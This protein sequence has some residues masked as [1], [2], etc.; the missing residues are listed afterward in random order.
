MNAGIFSIQPSMYTAKLE[1]H[2][3][4]YAIKEN[5]LES[6]F[7]Y[8]HKD[9][10][11]RMKILSDKEIQKFLK[12]LKFWR[13]TENDYSL[14]NDLKTFF[15]H[16]YDKEEDF[17]YKKENH[18]VAEEKQSNNNINHKSY[19][20]G[21]Y[22]INNKLERFKNIFI[23][24]YFKTEEALYR[25]KY[26]IEDKLNNFDSDLFGV[27]VISADWSFDQVR[28]Y[29]INEKKEVFITYSTEFKELKDINNL[30]EFDF[31]KKIYN[32][33][34][35]K[36]EYEAP[37]IRNIISSKERKYNEDFKYNLFKKEDMV[38]EGMGCSGFYVGNYYIDRK[39]EIKKKINNF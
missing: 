35:E 6:W 19:Y 13:S 9:E 12:K 24:A 11:E 30:K 31:Q 16:V 22:K 33:K 26:K 36:F 25:S 21:N 34:F 20:F 15:D 14:P 17:K 1:N 8:V 29:A 32:L 10:I 27:F 2:Y 39:I 3:K 4:L 23:D 28:V 7:A 18:K 5:S 38:Y 37:M